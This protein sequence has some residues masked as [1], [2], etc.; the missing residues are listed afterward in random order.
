VLSRPVLLFLSLLPFSFLLLTLLL[1]LFPL[2]HL[3][4]P[5]LRLL[6]EELEKEIVVQVLH[7]SG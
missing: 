7:T 4:E 2:H 1:L 5:F 3:E 6:N